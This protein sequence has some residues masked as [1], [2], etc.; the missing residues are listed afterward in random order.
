[1]GGL[2]VKEAYLRGQTD[3][4]Y[5]EITNSVYSMLFLSTPHR[6]S[7]LAETLNKILQLSFKTAPRKYI[8]EL[9]AGS[10]GL[11]K[12][13]EDFRHAAPKLEIFSLYETRPTTIY[14]KPVVSYMTSHVI[15]S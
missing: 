15:R 7:N 4:S 2:I 9:V 10:G 8:D 14:G 12:L 13:N 5:Q 11:Q 1:M 6:G 3:P